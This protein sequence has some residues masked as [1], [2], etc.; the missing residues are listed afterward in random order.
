MADFGRALEQKFDA[1][2]VYR[3]RGPAFMHLAE[4]NKGVEDFT[5]SIEL[6]VDE[7]RVWLRPRQRWPIPS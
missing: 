4:W 1:A 6:G 3:Q 5:R 7:P 2:E